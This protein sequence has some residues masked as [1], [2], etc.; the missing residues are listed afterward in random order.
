MRL[1]ATGFLLLAVLTYA[2]STLFGWLH[3]AMGYVTAFS[4]AA[5]VGGIADWF[6]VVA[7][8]RHPLHLKFIPHTAILPAN[9]GRIAK[10]LA[11]FIHREA[12]ARRCHATESAGDPG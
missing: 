10:G 2:L 3:S 4:E 8:F 12:Q 6:V 1:V 7:L 9:K 11:D 5:V